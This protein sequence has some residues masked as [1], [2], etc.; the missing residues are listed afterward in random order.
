MCQ[1]LGPKKH[2]EISEIDRTSML[3]KSYQLNLVVT[4]GVSRET[5]SICWCAIVQSRLKHDES[6]KC[7]CTV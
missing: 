2:N 1:G 6:A 5:S 3:A 4:S 7:A